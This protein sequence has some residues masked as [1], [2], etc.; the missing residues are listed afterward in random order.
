[1]RVR[2]SD[3]AVEIRISRHSSDNSENPVHLPNYFI[4]V[5][6]SY[7][8]IN[9]HTSVSLRATNIILLNHI[10]Y[11]K[12]SHYVHKHVDITIQWKDALTAVDTHHHR[13]GLASR[14]QRILHWKMNYLLCLVLSTVCRT[15]WE[16]PLS[17]YRYRRH[18][19]KWFKQC[20]LCIICVQVS[21]SYRI[22]WSHIKLMKIV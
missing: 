22:G 9:V 2:N 15:H 17:T 8:N 4:W 6:L 16:K 7:I 20:I 1:M 5:F 13:Q 12:L 19:N 3:V 18:F 10:T 21:N 14:A 11:F